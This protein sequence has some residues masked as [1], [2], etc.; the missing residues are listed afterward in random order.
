MSQNSFDADLFGKIIMI[1]V[2]RVQNCLDMPRLPLKVIE[3]VVLKIISLTGEVLI[4]LK[5]VKG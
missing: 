2:R 1:E 4:S 5:V 3:S